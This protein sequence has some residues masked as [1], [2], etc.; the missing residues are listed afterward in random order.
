V[1]MAEE[2]ITKHPHLMVKTQVI[3]GLPGQTVESWRYTMQQ[4]VAKNMLPIWF[5][6]E[7]L[8]ASPAIYDPEYQQKWEFE[9][10]KVIRLGQGNSLYVTIIP[11]KCI[12]FSQ[13]DLAEMIITS[14]VCETIS[15]INLTVM[16]YFKSRIDTDFL[17]DNLLSSEGYLLLCDNLYYNWVDANV[18]SLTKD[19][20]GNDVGIY[21]VEVSYGMQNLLKNKKNIGQNW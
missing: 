7:P 13:R 6:N 1:A 3:C 18:F 14:I 4:V 17:I 9:Y 8:P 20:E 2:L 16:Q 19:F 10:S 21:G 11:K 12:S 15:V 5:I